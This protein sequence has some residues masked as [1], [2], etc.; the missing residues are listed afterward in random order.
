MK[1][2]KFTEGQIVFSI[3]QSEQ[4]VKVEEIC[5][6]MV[7]SEATFYNWKKKYG[8]LGVSELRELGQLKDKNARLNQMVADL[9]L[10]KQV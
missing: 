4:G 8:R 9:S 3:K 6:K 7:I 10:D 5:R 2:S 1:K